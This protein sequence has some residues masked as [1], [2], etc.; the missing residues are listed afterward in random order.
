MLGFSGTAK[1]YY[2]SS[3]IYSIAFITVYSRPFIREDCTANVLRLNIHTIV[4]ISF[5]GNT[6]ALSH[7]LHK[8]KVL[9]HHYQ[10]LKL[11]QKLLC[12]QNFRNVVTK[13]GHVIKFG[14]IWY[15]FLLHDYSLETDC[16]SKRIKKNTIRVIF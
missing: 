6:H 4:C 1:T 2:L 11:I 12:S 10:T 16:E 14:S 15:V 9:V 8:D 5:V 13:Q 7:M 3:I